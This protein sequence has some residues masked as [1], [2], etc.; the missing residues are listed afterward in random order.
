MTRKRK[1]LN[2]SRNVEGLEIGEYLYKEA[3]KMKKKKESLQTAKVES[4]K[5]LDKSEKIMMNLKQ[6]RL[7][8]YFDE[9]VGM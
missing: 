1:S 7:S 4:F 2:F 9:L 8:E 5:P 6:R 3:I